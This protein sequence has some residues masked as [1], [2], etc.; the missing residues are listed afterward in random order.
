MI[1]RVLADLVLL[2]HLAFILFVILGGF[3]TIR[4]SWLKWAHLP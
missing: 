4:W 1:W 3:L 2:L